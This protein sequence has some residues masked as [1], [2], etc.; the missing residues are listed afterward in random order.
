MNPFINNDYVT[1]GPETKPVVGIFKG[2]LT[3][4]V[5]VVVVENVDFLVP[6]SSLR[7]AT[8]DD[9]MRYNR[10]K[11]NLILRLPQL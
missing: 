5:G 11:D 10:N 3:D 8:I 4:P 1:F 2:E 7:E 6:L 9:A